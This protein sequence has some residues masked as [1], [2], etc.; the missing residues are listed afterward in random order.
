MAGEEATVRELIFDIYDAAI[1][2]ARW[3]QVLDK[4]ALFTGARG[5]ML[6][7][8]EGMGADRRLAASHMSE[9]YDPMVLRQY[10]QLH[11]QQELADQDRFALYSRMSDGVELIPDNV[12][13]DSEAELRSR[14]NVKM[15][16]KLDIFHRAGALLNKDNVFRDRFSM[17]FSRAHGPL[18]PEDVRK[19]SM[20]LP[21]VAKALNLSR[22]TEQLFEKFR[23]ILGYL[24]MLTVGVCLLSDGGSIVLRNREFQRQM[25]TYRV[26]RIGPTGKL[27]FDDASIDRAVRR[28]L[29]DVSNH[30]HF[31]ARPRK[32]A[33]AAILEGEDY[34][35]CI[36]IAP[37]KQSA[38]FGSKP[39]SGHILYSLDTTQPTS[40][41]GALMAN[42]FGLTEAETEVLA[43][44]AEGMTNR[45]ISD[46]REKSVETINTQTKSILAKTMS[47][48][49]TQLIRLATNLSANFLSDPLTR[50]GDEDRCQAPH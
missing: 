44:M 8:L 5:A 3:P 12:L 9:Y 31:G 46:R 10:L 6:F 43:L 30:G 50:M 1:D 23:S 22:P 16:E 47:A 17:Q 11:Q 4:I 38:E 33:I 34:R 35:L 42:L 49:R 45:E 36:E 27:L 14:P 21:H 25:D 37:L 39:L 7:T 2:P 19:T 32:E 41:N 13:A 28:L 24:D 20:I 18:S 29:A 26:F 48:N 40:I 15:M